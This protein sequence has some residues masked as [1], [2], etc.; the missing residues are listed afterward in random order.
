MSGISFLLISIRCPHSISAIK[1]NNVEME[2]AFAYRGME[3]LKI[4]AL[5]R[6][7]ELKTGKSSIGRFSGAELKLNCRY[8]ITRYDS[9]QLYRSHLRLQGVNVLRPVEL[10]IDD[11]LSPNS[12]SQHPL[13]LEACFHYQG[14]QKGQKDGRLEFCLAT[15]EMT[16]AAWKYGHD[17]QIVIDGTFGF[18]NSRML[19][20]VVLAVNSN[21]KGV[22]IA[23]L[24]FSAPSGATQTSANYNT[25]IL[26]KL[27]NKWKDH[28]SLMRDNVTFA[29]RVVITDTDTRERAALSTVW[30]GIKLLLCKFHIRQCWTN[31]RK[32]TLRKSESDFV[33][34]LIFQRIKDLE[35]K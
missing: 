25:A 1:S 27:L 2:N 32:K 9:C 23:F 4:A 15:T 11:W 22:P 29:P 30:S 26:T 21:K 19:L 8:H 14:F 12:T 31:R 24:F 6:E 18:C 35:E 16:D 28:C 3:P 5:R 20:F 17:S 33:P 34:S 13:L 7:K 10:N